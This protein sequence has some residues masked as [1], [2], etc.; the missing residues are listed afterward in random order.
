MRSAHPSAQLD[1]LRSSLVNKYKVRPAESVKM[2]PNSGFGVL[3]MLALVA[4]ETVV[5]VSATA[6]GVGLGGTGVEVGMG[7]GSGREHPTI[8]TANAT[9]SRPNSAR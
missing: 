5:G 4:G 1:L 7:V 8:R 2:L 6:R 9:D 3:M